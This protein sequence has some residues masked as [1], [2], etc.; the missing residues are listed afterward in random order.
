MK[1]I[2]LNMKEQER[3]NL[4]EKYIKEGGNK[5]RLTTK[6]DLSM[7]SVN[8]LIKLYKEKGKA[9]FIHG[10]R[11]R[12]P[13]NSLPQELVN[14]IITLYT[15]KYQG[16]NFT[17][18][19]QMINE[20]ENIKVSYGAVYTLLT[21][22]GVN[23]PRIHRATRR[24]R[25][26]EKILENRPDI[27]EEDLKVAIDHEVAIEDSHPRRERAK[28]FGEEIQMDGSLHNWFGDEKATLHL[29]IDNATGRI[30][31]GFFCKQETLCGYYNVFRQILINYGIPAKF[32]TDNRTV[33]NYESRKKKTEE[34]DVLTQFGYACRILGVEIETS[35][36]SQAKG[37]IERANETFQD[38]LVNELR[39][40]N[41]TTIEE[42]NRYLI[43]A[44]IPDF[45]KR[46]SMDHTKF[47]S[48]MEASPTEEKINL[49]L[50][51]LAPRKFD[52]G[53]AIKYKNVYYQ[54]Y[55]SNGNL[56]CFKSKTE[57]LVIKAF[58]GDL[59][60][61]VDEKVYKLKQLV[62]NKKVSPEFD[63][64]E[65]KVEK[66]PYIPPMSHPWKLQSFRLQ[67]ARAH[68]W[69]QFT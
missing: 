57:C 31:G 37:Q 23:S 51:V 38:R 17:H 28:Y 66:K 35:S 8:R 26:K 68:Q 2:E 3:F 32:F 52:N 53:S 67:E 56:V 22:A 44:F 30:V 11:N 15:G 10:N 6:L 9:G 4:I 18:F 1:E 36:V 12:R 60:V 5:Q 29:A 63:T 58:D 62:R 27:E 20:Q 13:A 46:F 41:I 50:A 64:E 33:F 43:E 14:K 48:V 55:D 49:T 39:L 42:A 7:R 59:Y 24:K 45:N 61:T 65:P 25:A 21:E 54:A 19:T 69:H 16:F 40:H 34:R 47:E